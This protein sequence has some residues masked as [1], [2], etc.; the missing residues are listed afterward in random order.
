MLVSFRLAGCWMHL[1]ILKEV[2]VFIV[3]T[4]LSVGRINTILTSHLCGLCALSAA[5]VEMNSDMKEIC[6]APRQR[7]SLAF[8]LRTY[9][10]GVR[11]ADT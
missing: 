3:R 11:M 8:C 6:H 4:V 9:F 7:T 1:E 2:V 5:G 10:K